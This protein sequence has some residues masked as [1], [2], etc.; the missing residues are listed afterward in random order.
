MHIGNWPSLVFETEVDENP[1]S[2]YLPVLK[3]AL[4]LNSV[5][6]MILE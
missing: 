6:R 3:L 1:F 4:R 2:S 5:Q